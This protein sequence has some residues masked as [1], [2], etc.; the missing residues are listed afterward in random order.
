MKFVL[1]D[2]KRIIYMTSNDEILEYNYLSTEI[3]LLIMKSK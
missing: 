3:G 1:S 2:Y